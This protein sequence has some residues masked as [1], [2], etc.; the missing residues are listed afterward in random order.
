MFN[1]DIIRNNLETI[2]VMD[3][4]TISELDRLILIRSL[5]GEA[6]ALVE[7]LSAFQLEEMFANTSYEV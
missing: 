1:L 4:N 2:G 6:K 3:K 7:R 5:S